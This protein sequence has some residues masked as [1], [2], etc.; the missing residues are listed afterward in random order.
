MVA[1]IPVGSGAGRAKSLTI[2]DVDSNHDQD[3][4]TY[5]RLPTAPT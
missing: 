1:H 3:S 2:D 5:I 4:S